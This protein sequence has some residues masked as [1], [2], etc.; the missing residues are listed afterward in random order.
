MKQTT[1]NRTI[2][3]VDGDPDISLS[4]KCLLEAHDTAAKIYSNVSEFLSKAQCTKSD[5]VLLD[6]DPKNPTVFQLLN[7]LIFSTDRPRIVVTTGASSA[8]KPDD[9]F[10]GE[11]IKV[12]VHPVLPKD[13]LSAFE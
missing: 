5:T 8:L 4:T 10:P 11:N 13:L 7:R 3:I 6:L 9:I 1:E 2:Y 12:L